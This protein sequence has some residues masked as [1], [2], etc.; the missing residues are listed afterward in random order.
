MSRYERDVPID[1]FLANSKEGANGRISVSVV[2][3]R[4][5]CNREVTLYD[6]P[7]PQTTESGEAYWG[8]NPQ[9]TPGMTFYDRHY[10]FPLHIGNT[11]A[12]YY[13]L[14]ADLTD[15]LSQGEL[16]LKEVRIDEGNMAYVS[17]EAKIGTR[18]YW[19]DLN[20]GAIPT[21]IH[22]YYYDGKRNEDIYYDE[23]VEVKGKGFF[24]KLTCEVFD[25]GR[26]VE[27]LRIDSYNVDSIPPDSSFALSFPKAIRLLDV[28]KSLRYSPRKSWS[29]LNLP[30]AGSRDAIKAVPLGTSAEP[31][32]PLPIDDAPGFPKYVILM[33]LVSVAAALWWL[34][35]RRWRRTETRIA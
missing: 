1:V 3:G 24:P 5:L 7:A 17:L 22:D 33:V 6:S 14:Y 23:I 26:R 31:E 21:K 15:T 11:M 10:K 13:D 35:G 9:I 34:G 2:P 4:L 30:K 27:L 20:R 28:P 29:L 25:G 8:Y 12:H 19:L 16:I 18:E 32:M